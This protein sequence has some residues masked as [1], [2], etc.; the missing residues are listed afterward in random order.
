ML[1]KDF[2]KRIQEDFEA[3]PICALLGPRQCGKTTLSRL[4]AE[5]VK[6]PVHIFDLEDPGDLSQLVNAKLTLERL[7]GLIIIDEVQLRPDLFPLLR[8]LVD[9]LPLRFLIL[10]SASPDLIRQTS[11][12][13]A[14]RI[15]YIEMTPFS[16][17]EVHDWRRLWE[18]GGYPRS[19]L[20]PNYKV[21]NRWRTGFISTYLEKDIPQLGFEV[22]PQM[23]RRFWMMLTHYHGGIFNAS[24]VGVSLG[25]T[26]KTARHY[27]DILEG[28]YMMRQLN[29]WFENIG[30][31]QVKSPKVFFRDSGL[32]HTLLGI[33]TEE[34]LFHHPK[35]GL[36]F[37][38]FALEE[39][40]RFHQADPQD[41][42]FWATQTGAELDLLIVKGGE[43]LGFEIKYT[44][45]PKITKSMQIALEDLKLDKLT[46]IVPGSTR[47]PLTEKIEVCGL[48]TYIG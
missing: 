22:S 23:I 18:R 48:E 39:V 38:G 36:S 45:H 12:T 41:C 30:K 6:G 20:A 32:F 25:I 29:P 7:E 40:A 11:E 42:Y 10:G 28:T 17:Q 1:R 8:V 21:S 3:T 33:K 4:Y 35:L 44:D 24:E 27:L 16:L 5:Q 26:H 19:Y 15:S 31:R 2:I 14:G 34:D 37:E 43:K 13:L 46:V 9:K 47:F